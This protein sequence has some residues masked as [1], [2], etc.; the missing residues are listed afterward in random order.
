MLSR[1]LAWRHVD[2]YRDCMPRAPRQVEPGGIYH[3]APR[4]NDGR[5]IFLDDHDCRVYLELLERV[6]RK[7]RWLVLG[8]CLMK[9]HVHL[10]VQV[11][12]ANLSVGMQELSSEYSR[13]WNRKHGRSGH[14]FRNR[15]T[16]R[17]VLSERHLLATARYIDLNPVVV[18]QK[19]R[20]EQW[21]WSSY[22]AHVGLVHAPS[23][24]ALSAFLRL[25]GPTPAKAQAAYKRFVQ[26]GRALVSDT[27]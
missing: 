20:P 1:R 21:E 22:R 19:F 13:R 16:Y 2:A 15:F 26:E 24:L 5:R 27:V 18:R 12:D 9:N 6:T 8:Y 7:H 23:F 25:F 4:G 17:P 14:L 3:V 11:P 10:L